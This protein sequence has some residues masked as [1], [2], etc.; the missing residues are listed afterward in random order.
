MTTAAAIDR[1]I[2]HAVILEMTGPS[3]RNEEAL[4]RGDVTPAT[5]TTTTNQ[6]TTTTPTTNGAM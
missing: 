5:T 2:H 1:L 6:P 3:I 4:K